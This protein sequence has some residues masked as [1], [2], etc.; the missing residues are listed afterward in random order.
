MTADEEPA[1][2]RYRSPLREQQAGHTRA[3]VISVAS[4]LFREMGWSATGMRDV[5]QSAGISVETVY[6][7]FR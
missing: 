2:R 4:E 1:R 7:N 5:A 3:A 6:A